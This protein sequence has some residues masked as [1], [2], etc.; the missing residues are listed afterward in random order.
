MGK[1]H[2]VVV[3]AFG[4]HKDAGEICRA[5]GGN[6][7]DVRIVPPPIPWKGSGKRMR[8]V[9]ALLSART[10]YS[11]LPRDQA[12]Q[13]EIDRLLEKMTFDLIQ[14]EGFWVGC[15]DTTGSGAM[16]IIDAHNVEHDILARLARTSRSGIRRLYYH[17]ESIACRREELAAL[18]RQNAILVTSERDRM[19][20][21]KDLPQIPAFVIPNGVDTT[22]FTPKLA[23]EEPGSLVFTGA[24]NYAPN[25]DG[26]LHFIDSVFPLICARVPGSVLYVVGGSPP[27]E[28]K[29]RAGPHI[30]VTGHVEDVRPYVW[31]ASVYVVPLRSGGGTRL[32]ILEALAMG[33]AIVTT[34]IGCEGLDVCEKESVLLADEPV[35]F[36]DAVVGLLRD[37]ARRRMLGSNGLALARE[38][39]DWTVV[40]ES[41]EEAYRSLHRSKPSHQSTHVM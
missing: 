6:L 19:L 31:Q 23:S 20:I 24:M 17:F 26:I 29:R 35:E 8:Q 11:A 38:K 36:A 18:G 28:L 12:M 37:I 30:V 5:I 41:L 14:A 7:L 13:R 3:V 9:T 4:N 1:C 32:K 21:G 33:K 40:G 2:E 10:G 25:A 39:Y 16:K 22:Y 27:P 34:S 15:F